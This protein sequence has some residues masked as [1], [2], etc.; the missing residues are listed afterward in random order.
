MKQYELHLEVRITERTGSYET[1]P[2]IKVTV[3]GL[4]PAN[5]DPQRYIRQRL[6]EEVKRSFS[7]SVDVIDNKTEEAAKAAAVDPLDDGIPF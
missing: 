2:V 5:V 4:L 7:E 1:R 3:D 6:A